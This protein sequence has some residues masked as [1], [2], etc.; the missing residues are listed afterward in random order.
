MHA[1]LNQYLILPVTWQEEPNEWVILWIP[2]NGLT[3]VEVM[4]PNGTV[5]PK[6]MSE[7]TQMRIICEK[8]LTTWK[9]KVIR[10]C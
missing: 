1:N 2:T 8:L 7:V 3:Q 9:K 5:T 6:R 10:G 4:I